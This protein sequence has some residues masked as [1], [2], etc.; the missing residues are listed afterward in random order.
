M[1]NGIGISPGDRFGR[2]TVVAILSHRN[3]RC[4]C[5]CGKFKTVY[6]GNLKK[7]NTTSCGCYRSDMR[8]THPWRDEET[9]RI[10]EIR[11][12]AVHGK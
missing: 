10:T 11:R 12:K 2:L 7:Q 5:D 6:L 3:V 1:K 9:A 4:K 8:K